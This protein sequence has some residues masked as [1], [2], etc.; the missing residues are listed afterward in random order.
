MELKDTPET[1]FASVKISQ[2]INTD[3]HF[4][5]LH[6]QKIRKAP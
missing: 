2:H 3:K 5:M 6:V 4:A 1:L